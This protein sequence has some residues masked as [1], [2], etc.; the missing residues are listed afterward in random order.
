MIFL[1]VLLVIIIAIIL[2]VI[3]LMIQIF[4]H[5]SH[6]QENSKKI[7]YRI[8]QAASDMTA[9]TGLIGLFSEAIE[10]FHKRRQK[11][12]RDESDDNQR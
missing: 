12:P 1:I 4:R 5:I 7:S 11:S 10:L 2:V 9:V 3:A 8:D 6:A